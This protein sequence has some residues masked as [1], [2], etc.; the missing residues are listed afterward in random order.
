MDRTKKYILKKFEEFLDKYENDFIDVTGF[1]Q[2]ISK[3]DMRKI[4]RFHY[5]GMIKK[6]Q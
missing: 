4:C 6:E 5:T 3:D 2:E 1:V